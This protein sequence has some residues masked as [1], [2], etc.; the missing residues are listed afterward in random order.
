MVSFPLPPNSIKA[1]FLPFKCFSL[2]VYVVRVLGD[3]VPPEDLS[4]GGCF[5]RIATPQARLVTRQAART[6]RHHEHTDRTQITRL[7]NNYTRLTFNHF[8]LLKNMQSPWILIFT[9]RYTVQ[10]V[11]WLLI[12][13]HPE[14]RKTESAWLKIRWNIL[15]LHWLLSIFAS[16]GPDLP[17]IL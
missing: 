17:V 9:F 1:I 14:L 13:W 3:S 11:Q 8:I 16:K 5:L 15:N 12:R 7:L 10:H 4:V 2:I 6:A